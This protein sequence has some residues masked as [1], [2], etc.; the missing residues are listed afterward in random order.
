[1]EMIE[2]EIQGNISEVRELGIIALFG[3]CLG[4]IQ[5]LLLPP[6]PPV[7]SLYRKDSPVSL[8]APAGLNASLACAS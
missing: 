2:E 6:P 5:F 1:M 8:E 4:I 3:G 7:L